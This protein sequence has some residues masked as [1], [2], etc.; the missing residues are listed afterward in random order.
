MQK[1]KGC[2]VSLSNKGAAD[3]IYVWC[4]VKRRKSATRRVHSIEVSMYIHRRLD[5]GK[6]KRKKRKK[7]TRKKKRSN[8]TAQDST[9]LERSK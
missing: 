6:K 5:A 8:S 4:G 9:L 2:G 1:K 3:A 7:V